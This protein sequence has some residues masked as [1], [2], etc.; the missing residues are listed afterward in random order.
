MF[1]SRLPQML[2]SLDG[3]LF[4]HWPRERR[5]QRTDIGLAID[6]PRVKGQLQ[7]RTQ[8]GRI[9]RRFARKRWRRRI[10]RVD[11]ACESD[12]RL[13]HCAAHRHGEAAA[14]LVAAD[15]DRRRDIGG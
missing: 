8:R 9:S 11:L 6:L 10:A 14:E 2:R 15:L 5:R 13:R 4:R 12:R 7:V 3:T 1:T